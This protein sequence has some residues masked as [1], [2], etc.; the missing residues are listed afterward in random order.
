MTSCPQAVYEVTL[1]TPLGVTR[2]FSADCLPPSWFDK[3]DKPFAQQ[4]DEMLMVIQWAETNFKET[5]KQP[6]ELFNAWQS[7]YQTTHQQTY[8]AGLPSLLAAFGISVVERAIIDG[9]CRASGLTLHQA[10]RENVIGIDA[11]TVHSALPTLPKNWLPESPADS[12]FVRHTVGLGDPL[13]EAELNNPPNER[14]ND[15]FPETLEQYID[16]TGT[17]YFKVKVS[18][19]LDHD[20]ARLVTIAKL[21]E[22]K[23]SSDYTVTLDGNELYETAAQFDELVDQIETHPLLKTFW[24]NTLLIEQP[25]NREIALSAEHTAGIKALSER[26]IVIIDESDG[27]VDDFPNAVELGYRGVSSKNCK[28]PI[29]SILNA[30]LVWLNNAE[31]TRPRQVLTG[32]DLCTVGII[33]TQSDLALVAA[34]GITHVERNGHHYHPGLNYLS[35]IERRE[36]LQKHGDLY[37]T[38][39][40]RVTP[41]VA[42]GK[43]QIG[44]LQCPGYGFAVEPNFEAM[45]SPSEFVL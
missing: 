41:R 1:E 18:N 29:K 15:G 20:I 45:Q 34:L 26:K 42:D 36:A 9:I 14:L 27:T 43:F 3:A 31:P 37:T 40:G 24:S 10:L 38:H 4:I 22:T 17:Q 32:E 25:L 21:I 8:F 35:E 11:S 23:R 19:R 2:G 33:P 12:V 7:V 28:G 13:T 5:M 44:T 30:G 6:N 39:A 16:G